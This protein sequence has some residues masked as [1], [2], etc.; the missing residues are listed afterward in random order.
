MNT[1]SAV[2][3]SVLAGA[4]LASG[5]FLFSSAGDA[6]ST[7]PEGSGAARYLPE[8]TANGDLILPKNWR[9]CVRGIATHTEC[10]Q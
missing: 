1:K 3:F 9:H 6:Q 10:A 8:C 7:A 4:S 2:L 5:M